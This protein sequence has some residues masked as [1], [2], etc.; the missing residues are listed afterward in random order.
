MAA[1]NITMELEAVKQTD[2]KVVF[3]ERLSDSPLAI[4]RVTGLY[5]DKRDLRESGWNGS[6]ITMSLNFNA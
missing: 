6:P 5:L 3:A 1:K 2:N 4:R